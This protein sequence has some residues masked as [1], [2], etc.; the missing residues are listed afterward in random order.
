MNRGR[1]VQG[2]RWRHSGTRSISLWLRYTRVN[3]DK[4]GRASLGLE[5]V[6]GFFLFCFVLFAGSGEAM[7]VRALGLA[8]HFKD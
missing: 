7:N 4:A 3:G 5:V 6:V 8:P 1:N 2:R